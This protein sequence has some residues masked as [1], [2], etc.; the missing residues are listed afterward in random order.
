[1]NFFRALFGGKEVNSEEKKKEEEKRSFD[2]LKYDGVRAMKTGQAEFAVQCF[3][4]A[5]ELE[6]DLEIRDYLS[7]VLI[8]QGELL[9]AY[10]ELR[11]LAEAEPENQEI[12][13]RMAHVAYMMEDYPMMSSACEKALLV[14]N[15]NPEVHYL[16]AKACI[17]MEDFVNGVAMLTKAITLNDKFGDA[18]LLRGDTLLKMGDVAAAEEDAAHLLEHVAENEDVLLLKAR[19]EKKKGDNE[20]AV[21][22]YGKVID[23]NPFSIPAHEE[24][25]VTK[26]EMGDKEGAVEDMKKVLEMT[27]EAEQDIN[28]EFSSEGIEQIVKNKYKD[29]DPYGIFNTL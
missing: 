22:Y 3:R 24:R 8:H 18:Y 4:K 12:L 7:Q 20:S 17:G 10:E 2:A 26:L 25:G 1:M 11:K 29:I 16:Y 14:N 5:L 15:D 21:I 28:G 13:L 9:P 6:E 23:T 27:P 19:I